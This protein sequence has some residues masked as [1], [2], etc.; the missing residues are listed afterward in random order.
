MQFL[1]RDR[2]LDLRLLCR[3][4]LNGH[5]PVLF[6]GNTP[7]GTHQSMQLS[8]IPGHALLHAGQV[9]LE[10]LCWLVDDSLQVGDT[11]G[12]VVHA[13]LEGACPVSRL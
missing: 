3:S 5:S 13:L 7:L 4:V 1:L 8:H 10:L 11:S 9:L 6:N 2:L 12:P